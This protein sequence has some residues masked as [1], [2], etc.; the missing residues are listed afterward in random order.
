M[1]NRI[2]KGNVL[3][4][5]A[6]EE[7]FIEVKRKKLCGNNR[8]NKNIK[9]VLLKPETLYRP[10]AKQSTK[11]TSNSPKAILFVGTNKAFTSGCNKYFTKSQRNKGYGFSYDINL[12]S[13]SYTFKALNVEHPAIEEVVVGNKATTFAT[14]E[15]RLSTIPLR[16]RFNVLEKQMLEGKLMF[17]DDDG[18]PL[19]KL[20]TWVIRVTKMKLNKL[21]MKL[22]VIWHRN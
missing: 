20:I 21:I 6:V 13:L 15:K 14:R 11:G 19:E 8:G 9:P 4:S 7:C 1:V 3:T 5:W 2:D 18:K 17:V 22:Q 10:K 12:F 16:E